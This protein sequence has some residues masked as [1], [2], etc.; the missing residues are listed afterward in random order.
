MGFFSSSVYINWNNP[1]SNK[2]KATWKK[3]ESKSFFSC[4]SYTGLSVVCCSTVRME[5]SGGA[6]S[7]YSD[8]MVTVRK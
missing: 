6:G 5:S 3:V 8:F 1:G 2:F 4:R 7:M